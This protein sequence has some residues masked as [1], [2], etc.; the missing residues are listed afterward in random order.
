VKKLGF[1]APA[2]VPIHREEVFERI[3]DA[4]PDLEVPVPQ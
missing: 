2:E 1:T 4:W 3:G